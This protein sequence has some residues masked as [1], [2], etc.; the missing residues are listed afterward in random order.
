MDEMHRKRERVW[1]KES[2]NE[3]ENRTVRVSLS[4]FVCL[5]R[6]VLEDCSLCSLQ[7]DTWD[8]EA[9]GGGEATVACHGHLHRVITSRSLARVALGADASA[10]IRIFLSPGLSSVLSFSSHSYTK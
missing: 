4:L 7:C 6:S 2:E 8:V 5:L 3:R 1:E 9:G 10:C